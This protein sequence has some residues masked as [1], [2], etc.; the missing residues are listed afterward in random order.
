MSDAAEL[1]KAVLQ[2]SPTERAELAL[3]AWE[4][5]EADPAFAADRGLDAEGI[6]VAARRDREIES[7]IVQPLTDEEFRRHTPSR[8]GL[9]R[10]G[11]ISS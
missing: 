10:H 7:G 3:L 1:E 11:L 6:A 4:S 5:L 8:H 9:G 2:L